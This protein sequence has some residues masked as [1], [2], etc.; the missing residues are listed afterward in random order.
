MTT[1]PRTLWNVAFS[2]NYITITTTVAAIDPDDAMVLAQ[3]LIRDE[4][5]ID[6]WHWSATADDTERPAGRYAQ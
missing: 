6:V 2:H 4:T 1:P 5:D 3:D